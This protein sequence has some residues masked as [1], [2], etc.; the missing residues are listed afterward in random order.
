[1]KF[2]GGSLCWKRSSLSIFGDHATIE[3]E[4]RKNEFVSYNKAYIE[5]WVDLRQQGSS[6]E[7]LK[8]IDNALYIIALFQEQFKDLLTPI[9]GKKD[10]T[11]GDVLSK[12]LSVYA[13]SISQ[14][15]TILEKDNAGG[16]I[17]VHK[18]DTR[19]GCYNCGSSSHLISECPKRRNNCTNCGRSG[20]LEKYCWRK[21]EK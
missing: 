6:D 14:M 8:K 2:D 11:E 15:K 4:A 10:W 1:M 17:Q 7:I 12:E 3:T 13:E 5:L 19:M 9:Y 20:R 21:K 18:S 16:V